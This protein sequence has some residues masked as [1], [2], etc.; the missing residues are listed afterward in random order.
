MRFLGLGLGDRVPDAK[1]IWL[2]REHFVQVK[3]IEKLFARFDDAL[4][5]AGYLAMGG[6]IIDATVV[7]APR[8]KLSD[9]GKAAIWG[10]GTP[11]HW[12]Q[13]GRENLLDLLHDV[14]SKYA[15]GMAAA[16][17]LCDH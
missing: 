13:I 16:L 11:S 4:H 10:G 5:G 12:S 8:Q 2:F 7:A 1:T 9:E 17:R 3:A 6:Q 15:V 14:G